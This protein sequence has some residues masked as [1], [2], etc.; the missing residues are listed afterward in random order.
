MVKIALFC[1]TPKT[2]SGITIYCNSLKRL[3][4]SRGD[5]SLSVFSN[6]PYRWR[7][8]FFQ[9]YDETA[10]KNALLSDNFDIIH[11]NGFISTIPF[12]IS[13]VMKALKI[14]KPVVYTPHAH[15]FSTLNHP[16]LNRVFFHLYVKHVLR[17]SDVV[18][19]INK[20][21]FNF[22][23][24]YNKN[25]VTIP[26]WSDKKI[27]LAVNKSSEKKII[28]FVGRNDENKN[29]KILYSLPTDKY[30]IICVT[31]TKPDRSDFIFKCCISDE[32]L[33]SLYK[34]ADLT[35]IPSR[36]EAFSYTAMESLLCGTPVLLSNRVRIADFLEN[37]SGVTVYDYSQ[38]TDFFYKIDEAM[39]KNV[40]VERVR[41]IF[42]DNQAFQA[43][44]NIY[45]S[46]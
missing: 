31:N 15:P 39:N 2:K 14:N 17:L 36:Y 20:E 21:D 10:I 12:Y 19:S 3:L 13:K 22:L 44:T 6:L 45:N 38:P 4:E 43:Y 26:H 9:V 32:E 34:E 37:V 42:S 27:N 7:F 18:I 16:F 29:L 30:K 46:F 41:Y 33:V 24:K 40:D 25:V 35:V 5:Y 11:I 8:K 1:D 28:L 23:S